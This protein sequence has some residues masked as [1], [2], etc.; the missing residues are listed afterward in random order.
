MKKSIAMSLALSGFASLA[1]AQSTVTL[2]GVVD[3]GLQYVSNVGG[4]HL[5]QASSGNLQGDRWG[6]KGTEDLGGNMKT[7]FVLENGFNI[8]NGRLGQ[9][10]D[11]FGRQAY[12]GLSTRYGTVTLGR[13]YDS[14]VDFVD[15]LGAATQWGTFYAAHAGDVDNMNNTNRM[16]NSIKYTSNNYNGLKFSAGYSLGGIAGASGRNQIITGGFGYSTGSFSLGA[17]YVDAR[18]PNYSFWGDNALSNTSASAA[19]SNNM[20]NRVFSGYAS[21]GREQIFAIAGAYI[22]GSFTAGLTYSNVQFKDLGSTA[23]VNL[24]PNGYSGAGK[25]HNTEMSLRYQVTPA[26]SVAGA[27]EY[28]HAYGENNANYNEGVVG[29]D[30]FISKRTDF[31]FDAIYMHA[32][33]ADSTGRAAV[34]NI[35]GL[36]ASSTQSQ[37][38]T[39]AG[40]RV[41][42]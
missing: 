5:F 39:I 36:S 1:N 15:P 9:G 41:K 35:N 19:G 7:V 31:Y 40:M 42:F 38:A 12:V 20:D 4:H 33:G 10:G 11:Q 18:N 8:Y 13:Q 16:N 25:F 24:N 30:Y 22:I 14:V 28:T 3:A 29:L 37:V 34:A 17:G 2:Y 32:S 6:L 27:W 23:G 21:A 26:F